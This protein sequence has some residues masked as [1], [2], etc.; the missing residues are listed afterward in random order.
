MRVYLTILLLLPLT[1]MAK[2]PSYMAQYNGCTMG[3]IIEATKLPVFPV[4]LNHCT[5]ID[6]EEYFS[7]NDKRYRSFRPRWNKDAYTST[8]T[9]SDD[10]LASIEQLKSSK[11]QQELIKLLLK[12]GVQ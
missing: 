12:Q 11:E 4:E 9:W 10:E 6:T 8:I 2:S 7:W 3:V 1:S 5:L